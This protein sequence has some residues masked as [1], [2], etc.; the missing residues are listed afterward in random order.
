M[1]PSR[2]RKRSLPGSSAKGT[3]IVSDASTR[4]TVLDY[5]KRLVDGTLAPGDETQLNYPPPVWQ[6]LGYRLIEVDTGRATLGVTADAATHGSQLGTV[7]GGFLSELA[8]AAMGTAHTT[9]L[10]PGQTLTTVTLTVT[11]LRPVW[12]EALLA[13]AYPTHLGRTVSHYAVEITRQD[14]KAV[15]TATSTVVTISGEPAKTRSRIGLGDRFASNLRPA[16]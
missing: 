14:G 4:M 12:R 10:E 9:T 13:R 8:D 15:A 5:L 1:L 6:L 11:F 16:G 3:L 2:N 7:H